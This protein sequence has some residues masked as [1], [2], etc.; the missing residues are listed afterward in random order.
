MKTSEAKRA[1]RSEDLEC[2]AEK[3]AEQFDLIELSVLGML[4]VARYVALRL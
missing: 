1:L 2:V 4:A 3:P